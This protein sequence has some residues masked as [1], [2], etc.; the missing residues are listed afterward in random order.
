MSKKYEMTGSPKP[1]FKTKDEFTKAITDFG[2][3][4]SKMKK[5]DNEC[6]VLI[7]DDMSKSSSKMILANEL[8]VEIM[9]YEEITEL[10]GLE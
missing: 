4:H 5:R 3:E 2:W 6:Q 10:F 1:Y 7:T 9:T 8:G